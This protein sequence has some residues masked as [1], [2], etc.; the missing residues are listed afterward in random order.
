MIEPDA[1]PSFVA[2]PLP[3]HPRLPSARVADTRKDRKCNQRTGSQ[4][5]RL[6]TLVVADRNLAQR[7]ERS[8]IAEQVHTCP[9]NKSFERRSGLASSLA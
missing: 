6:A 5:S 2:V 3:V 9:H 7:L 1:K 8:R 4:E